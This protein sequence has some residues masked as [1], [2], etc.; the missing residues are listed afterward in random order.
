MTANF[1]ALLELGKPAPIERARQLRLKSQRRIVIVD[2]RAE[3]AHLHVRS[4]HASH[5]SPHRSAP[6][7]AP[8][9]SP[10]APPATHQGWRGSNS[11]RSMQL[12]NWAQA[13]LPRHSRGPRDRTRSFSGRFRHG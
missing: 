3:L 12:S 9:C 13:E 10:P 6:T 8:Y 5:T 11:V 7:E 4:T 1:I 2:G